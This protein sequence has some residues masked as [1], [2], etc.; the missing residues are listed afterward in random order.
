MLNPGF[1]FKLLNLGLL[2][3]LL[4]SLLFRRATIFIFDWGSPG[5]NNRYSNNRSI[6]DRGI[7]DRGINDREISFAAI[8]NIFIFI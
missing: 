5:N 8:R 4:K 2:N 1:Q 6:K 3:F 7:K